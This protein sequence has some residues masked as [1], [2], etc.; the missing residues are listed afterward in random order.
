MYDGALPDGRGPR[1]GDVANG[2]DVCVLGPAL[3]EVTALTLIATQTM[4]PSRCRIGASASSVP[5]ESSLE[6]RSPDPVSSAIHGC[7][8]V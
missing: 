4:W 8:H 2:A 6:S 5:C 7:G 3:G 1:G